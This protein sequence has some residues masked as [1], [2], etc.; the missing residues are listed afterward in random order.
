MDCEIYDD[1]TRVKMQRKNVAQL[2]ILPREKPHI[3]YGMKES[4]VLENSER[5]GVKWKQ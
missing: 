1:V 5:L 4:H 2:S 3:I